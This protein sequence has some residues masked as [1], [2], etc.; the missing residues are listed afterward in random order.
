MRRCRS[1]Q[2]KKQQVED[3]E[4]GGGGLGEVNLGA[5][6]RSKGTLHFLC[7]WCWVWTW[8]GYC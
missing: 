8:R 2:P 5:E 3:G 6:S 1:G 4:I 7:G